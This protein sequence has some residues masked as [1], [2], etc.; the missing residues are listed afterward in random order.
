MK[1]Y[2]AIAREIVEKIIS[3]GLVREL[4]MI[5]EDIDAPRKKPSENMMKLTR[6]LIE[7]NMIIYVDW[8]TLTGRDL[9]INENV[10][11]GKAYAW[12]VPI[13]RKTLEA[14]LKSI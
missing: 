6:I 7:K 9:M 2:T 4:K 11:I 14:A 3:L 1:K 10:G 5:L 13:F 12:Q 8:S